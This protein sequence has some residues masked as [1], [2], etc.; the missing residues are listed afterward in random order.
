M[1]LTVAKKLKVAFVLKLNSLTGIPSSYDKTEIFIKYIRGRKIN[2]STKKL[3][4]T[5][6]KIVYGHSVKFNSTLIP[7]DEKNYKNKIMEISIV[8]VKKKKKLKKK[9]I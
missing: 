4:P 7:K 9:K 2:G 5:N 8:A 6:G 3:K 1:K